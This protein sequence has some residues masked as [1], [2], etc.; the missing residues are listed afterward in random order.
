MGIPRQAI[1][2]SA[3][4]VPSPGVFRGENAVGVGL[5]AGKKLPGNLM[6]PKSGELVALRGAEALLGGLVLLLFLD[7]L[8][9][10]GLEHRPGRPAP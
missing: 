7:R 10:F 4:F 1:A 2:E 5:G 6:P 9:E 3:V 8:P